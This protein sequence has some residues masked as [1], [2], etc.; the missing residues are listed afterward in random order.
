MT[1]SY[2]QYYARYGTTMELDGWKMEN[3]TGQQVVYIK[4][5]L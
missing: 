1:L 3:P 4:T 5:V 2:K